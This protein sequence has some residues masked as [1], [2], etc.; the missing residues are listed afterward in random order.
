[1]AQCFFFMLLFFLDSCVI[2]PLTLFLIWSCP[3]FHRCRLLPWLL[4]LFLPP[5]TFSLFWFLIF[6]HHGFD[7]SI[8]T[9]PRAYSRVL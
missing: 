2:P 8:A 3:I 5:S 7:E 6:N 9:H 4:L 1:M